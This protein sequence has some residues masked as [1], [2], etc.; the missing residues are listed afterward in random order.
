MWIQRRIPSPSSEAETASSKSRAVT[1]STV[2]VSSAV[3]SRRSGSTRSAARRPPPRA[4]SSSA[5]VEPALAA[6]LPDQRRGDVARRF[7]VADLGDHAGA[8]AVALDD[9][10]L[11]AAHPHA[12]GDPDLRGAALE[13]RLGDEE[14]P[15]APDDGDEGG[16]HCEV[17]LG[18]E[19][20]R[21]GPPAPRSSCLVVVLGLGVVRDAHVGLHALAED[22]GPVRG[23][24]LADRQVERAAR[25]AGRCTS[26]KVPLP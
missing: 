11:A 24:V 9:D 10:H 26:W 2:N 21:R 7:R 12:A 17:A 5:R 3:R 4:S 14:A 1:G 22:R 19:L 8:G 6:A 13:Q 25:R 16:R 23:Q 15:A 18:G 20:A